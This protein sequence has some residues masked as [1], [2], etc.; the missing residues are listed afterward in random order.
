MTPPSRTGV[1]PSSPPGPPF[2]FSAFPCASPPAPAAGAAGAAP[3]SG[4]FFAFSAMVWAPGR[5][6]SSRGSDKPARAQTS[7][8]HYRQEVSKAEGGSKAEGRRQKD[9]GRINAKAE[10]TQHFACVAPLPSAFCLLPSAFC[11]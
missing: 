11:R 8:S 4:F 2:F 5:Q 7:Q 10:D 6:R 1:L 3:A 9:G